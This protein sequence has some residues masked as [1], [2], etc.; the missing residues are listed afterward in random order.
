MTATAEA[1]TRG[2]EIQIRFDGAGRPLALRWEGRLWVVDPA[3]EPQHWFGHWDECAG[4]TSATG[5]IDDGASLENW[6]AQV[7]L[8]AAARPRTLHLQKS[9]RSLAWHLVSIVD[10]D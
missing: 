5:S 3:T 6:R 10:G 4:G 8:S 9:P 7:R 1:P 2:V